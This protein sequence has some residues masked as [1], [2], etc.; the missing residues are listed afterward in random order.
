M[1]YQETAT[2]QNPTGG[3]GH[4]ALSAYRYARRLGF[5]LV[6]TDPE[7]HAAVEI[8]RVANTGLEPDFVASDKL[9]GRRDWTVQDLAAFDELYRRAADLDAAMHDGAMTF[10]QARDAFNAVIVEYGGQAMPFPD[11]K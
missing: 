10:A 6:R 4:F 11:G 1:I 7:T 2:P 5:F 3:V 9:L 8:Q